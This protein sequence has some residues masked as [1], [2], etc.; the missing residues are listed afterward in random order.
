MKRLFRFA[1]ALILGCLTGCST[2]VSTSIPVTSTATDT[3]QSPVADSPV[4]VSIQSQKPESPRTRLPNG[5]ARTAA[6]AGNA[7]A[8]DLY[9]RLR[10]ASQGNLF[11]SPYSIHSAL[12]MTYAGARG[13][14]AAEMARSLHLEGEQETAVANAASLSQALPAG[15]RATPQCELQIANRLWGQKGL[16]I[17]PAFTDLTRDNFGAG[18]ETVDFSGHTEEARQAINAWVAAQTR[19]KILDL[20]KAG[21]IDSSTKLVLTNAIYF[22]GQWNKTFNKNGTAQAPFHVSADEKADVPLMFQRGHFACSAV[23]GMQILELPYV[24]RRLAMTILLSEKVDGLA[25]IEQQLSPE[26]LDR[27]L[28]KLESQEAKVHFPRFRMTNDFSLGPVLRSLGMALAQTPGQA[29]FS[30]IAGSQGSAGLA[31]STDM[32]ISAVI[33]KAFVDVNEEG[34]EA[35]AATAVVKSAPS[36]VV[37][38]FVFRADHPFLF[39]IRDTRTGS[40]LFLGRMVK[41]QKS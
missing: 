41:P 38:T 15:Q 34:T 1:L 30:G 13:E 36:P 6:N 18:L 40:I 3:A 37:K 14:T 28:S 26:N 24:D 35:A 11:F 2:E 20:L 19:N 39:L 22:K 27:W 9:S 29:D 16:N 12:A 10:T 21:T 8:V 25:A 33:H 31:V 32:Y 23:E 7:F 5:D 4:T 17:L